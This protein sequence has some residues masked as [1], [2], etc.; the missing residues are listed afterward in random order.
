MAVPLT[1]SAKPLPRPR[2]IPTGLTLRKLVTDVFRA[3]LALENLAPR[4]ESMNEQDDEIPGGWRDV[5]H[6]DGL[7]G[8]S[9]EGLV[10]SQRHALTLADVCVD[11]TCVK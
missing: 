4:E 6:S 8:T 2:R 7:R 11:P 5:G 1:L 9:P 10:S 3:I